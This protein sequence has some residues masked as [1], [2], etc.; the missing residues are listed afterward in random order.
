MR[1]GISRVL[2]LAEAVVAIPEP[3]ELRLDEI[4]E[5]VAQNTASPEADRLFEE[6]M[7]L[8]REGTAQSLR[9]AI[10]LD[11]AIH[12]RQVEYDTARSQHLEQFGYRVIRFW[13]DRVME[14]LPGVLAEIARIG[15]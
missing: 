10:E 15:K 11:G 14:D 7:Q 4:V 8:Y 5:Q 6:G 9:G 13:N 12:D 2:L 1:T 3:T